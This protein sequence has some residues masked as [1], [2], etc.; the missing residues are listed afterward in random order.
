MKGDEQSVFISICLKDKWIFF[1]S[2]IQFFKCF[3]HSL[4]TKLD[5]Y[6]GNRHN[7]WVYIY[8][9]VCVY[10]LYICVYIY[11]CVYVYI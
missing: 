5:F 3:P 9:C 7:V 4:E 6:E 11:K 8:M 1:F 2:K 10:K